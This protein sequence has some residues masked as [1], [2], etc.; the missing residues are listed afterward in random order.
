[1]STRPRNSPAP[2]HARRQTPTVVCH[3]GREYEVAYNV[4]TPGCCGKKYVQ[5]KF[6]KIMRS[7]FTNQ[8]SGVAV[9]AK[10]TI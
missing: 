10:S 1:M 9:P 7:K 3:F 2:F 4:N 8:F 5:E 6:C